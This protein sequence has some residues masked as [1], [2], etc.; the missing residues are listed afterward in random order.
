MFYELCLELCFYLLLLLCHLSLPQPTCLV[1]FLTCTRLPNSHLFFVFNQAPLFK[2]SS[3]SLLHSRLN[4]TVMTQS[5]WVLL[6]TMSI[7]LWL[8]CTD[9]L[10]I[11]SSKVTHHVTMLKS[12]QT[13]FLKMAMSPLCSCDLKSDLSPIGLRSLILWMWWNE[14]STQGMRSYPWGPVMLISTNMSEE[15]FGHFVEWT[16]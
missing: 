11:T 16:Q 5:T 2:S 14:K 7:P 4:H 12:S 10:M 1:P 3:H 9:I 13:S 6:L 15:C 8:R